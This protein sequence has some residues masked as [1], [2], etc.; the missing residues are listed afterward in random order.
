MEQ[1]RPKK[2]VHKKKEKPEKVEERHKSSSISYVSINYSLHILW[3]ACA[4][5]I[6][7]VNKKVEPYEGTSNLIDH[8]DLKK[9]V[10]N[11]M[12][13]N[14]RLT[15]AT[16]KEKKNILDSCNKGDDIS[17]FDYREVT[18]IGKEDSPI[19][20]EVMQIEKEIEKVGEK[21]NKKLHEKRR[22]W[23]KKKGKK[24][25]LRMLRK[26]K[27]RNK[28]MKRMLRMWRNRKRRKRFII[29]NTSNS[30]IHALELLYFLRGGRLDDHTSHKNFD[31]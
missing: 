4:K 1:L 15:K 9:N 5:E 7:R 22:K 6:Q 25:M 20:E 27:R 24:W 10:K 29:V 2:V 13:Q 12:A 3:D 11:L 18:N 17:C 8:K 28:G 14:D 21:K 31:R 23:R 30:G 19:V 16:Q 26:K